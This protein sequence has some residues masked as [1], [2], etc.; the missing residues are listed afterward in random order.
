[1]ANEN[2]KVSKENAQSPI[3][4]RQLLVLTG[5]A[6]A[7][8][9]LAACGGMPDKPVVVGMCVGSGTGMPIA[10]AEQ[11]AVGEAKLFPS[12][13]DALYIIARDEQGFM[14]MKNYCT[15]SGCGLRVAAD[16]TYICDCHNSIFGFDGALIQGPATRPLDHVAMCRRSDGM[17]VVDKTKTLPGLTGR[18]T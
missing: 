5:E 17:L 4:R 2:D 15:H 14:A 12:S 10:G 8:G 1:M 7:I 18:V 16:K 3:S 11:V 9:T 6:A 13:A